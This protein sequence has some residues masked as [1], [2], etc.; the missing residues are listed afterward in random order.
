MEL[1]MYQLYLPM[2]NTK[3]QCVTSMQRNGCLYD[4]FQRTLLTRTR[5]L[6][7]MSAYA[8]SDISKYSLPFML[9]C[10]TQ[11]YIQAC[12]NALLSVISKHATLPYSV[13]YPSMRHITL[14]SFSS[15]S[16]SHIVPHVLSYLISTLPEYLEVPFT[17]R[18]GVCGPSYM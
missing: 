16:R 5:W 18:M 15:K 13:L 4:Y 7:S 10:L 14:A 8:L 3:S 17:K 11:C 1:L 6:Y 12:D 9:H 2:N